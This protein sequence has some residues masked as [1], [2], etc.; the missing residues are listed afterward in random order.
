MRRVLHLI[1]CRVGMP[2]YRI[3]RE[4]PAHELVDWILFFQ[5]ENRDSE[6]RSVDDIGGDAFAAAMGAD[7]GG[8]NN[9]EQSGPAA[10]PT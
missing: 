7:V 2:V 9:G 1:A 10:N 4:M 3:E 5:A 6:P 8:L